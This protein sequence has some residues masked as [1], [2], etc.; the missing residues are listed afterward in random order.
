MTTVDSELHAL[1]VALHAFRR[2]KMQ[3][4]YGRHRLNN[5]GPAI[6]MGDS[7]LKQILECARLHKLNTVEDVVRE[8][9]W[10][11]AEDLGADVLRLIQQY[12][13]Y[14]LRCYSSI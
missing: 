7:Q 1:H 8:I 13:R 3:Q 6:I 10:W 4:T 9:Q 5:L 12:V 14:N 11:R 2:E